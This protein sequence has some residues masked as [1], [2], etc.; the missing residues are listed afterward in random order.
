MDSWA[1]QEFAMSNL[2]DKRLDR[3]L[4]KIATTFCRA[5]NANVPNATSALWSQTKAAY[6]FFNNPKVT[7][8]NILAPHRERTGDR[9]EN[10]KVVLSVQDSSELKYTKH[11]GTE[12]LGYIG[13]L[14][15]RGILVHPTLLVTTEGTP[16]GLIDLK[17]WIRE[18]TDDEITEMK[19]K[20]KKERDKERERR[21][22]ATTT[23]ERESFK[24][25]ESYRC[26]RDFQRATDDD[27]IFVSVCDREGDIY[28]LF[29]E[30]SPDGEGEK[31]GLLVRAARNRVVD[32]EYRYLW[33]TVESHP[34][35]G[36]VTVKVPRRK[37]YPA[38][39]AELAVRF[40]PITVLPPTHR[41]KSE[42]LKPVQAWA[43]YADEVNCPKGAEKVSWMLLN[44][45]PVECY[46]D[47]LERL[48]WYTHRWVIESFF[49]V[50]KSG[51][52]VEA[53][54]LRHRVRLEKCVAL[55]CVI[56]WR[57]LFLTLTGRES[58]DLPASVLFDEDEWKALYCYVNSTPN[59]PDEEPRLQDVI[60]KIAN[61][62]GFLGRKSDGEPG[63]TTLWVGLS[64]LFDIAGVYKIFTK[65]PG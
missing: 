10:R 55:D 48:K 18:A 21:R 26:T 40:C 27:T 39:E 54:Q 33:E 42:G 52:K 14:N 53:R 58:P 12:G 15:H 6:R 50:L 41:P 44:T 62:G 59:P 65:A 43:V 2:G 29:A 35:Q 46:E 30:T 25:I 47:A 51:C 19:R 28:D 57:I 1:Q 49:R 3:R 60:R 23:E 4:R 8:E 13:N 64:R 34:V 9:I 16:L 32:G 63:M 37:N 45:I 24:W 7:K 31:P 5:P 38:R 11:P 61:L 20:G 56:A 17:T 22:Y 36:H